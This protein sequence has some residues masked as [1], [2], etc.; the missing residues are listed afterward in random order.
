MKQGNTYCIPLEQRSQRIYD[1][2]KLTKGISEL[3]LP[4]AEP[5][6]VL[7]SGLPGVGK[8]FVRR[9]LADR[10]PS[11]VLESDSLR[12][13]L[14][15]QPD[16]SKTESERLFKAIHL[17]AERYLKAGF[18]I[19]VDATNLTEYRRQYFY[20]IAKRAQVQLI[21]VSVK[22]PPSL[23]K[24]R[25]AARVKNQDDKSEADWE[26]Y[27]KMKPLVEKITRKHFVV[28]TSTEITSVIDKIMSEIDCM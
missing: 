9:R 7:I 11:V 23:V 24:E 20:N 17:L 27:K 3:P 14:F 2:D 15:S 21:I 16:Y 10:L 5:V 19:I 26:V 18:C 1:I 4:M 12:K 28:D 8:S 13:I 25:L 22:A 6:L